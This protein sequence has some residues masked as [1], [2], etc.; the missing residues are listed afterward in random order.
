MV[1]HCTLQTTG[2]SKL[3]VGMALARKKAEAQTKEYWTPNRQPRGERLSAL[4]L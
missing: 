1:R 2:R 4:A 3:G